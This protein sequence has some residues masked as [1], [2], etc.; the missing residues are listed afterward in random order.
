MTA[1]PKSSSRVPPPTT[2]E[3]SK[4]IAEQIERFVN[5]GGKID[6]IK[7]GV[8]GQPITPSGPKHIRLGNKEQTK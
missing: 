2:A 4:I 1:K 3:T 6:Y 5:K 8:S 7:T